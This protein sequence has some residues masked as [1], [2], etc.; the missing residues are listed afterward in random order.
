MNINVG[1]IEKKGGIKMNG[2]LF[3]N[4]VEGGCMR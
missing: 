4:E 3:P 2:I 1:L